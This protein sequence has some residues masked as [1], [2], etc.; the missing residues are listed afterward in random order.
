MLGARILSNLAELR[1]DDPALLRVMAWRLSQAGDLET[2]AGVLEKVLRLRPEEPQSKRDLA[3]V[4]A[5]LAEAV[6]KPAEAERA[7]DLLY[8]VVTRP[9]DR[10]PE[11]ELIALME[12]NRILVRAERRGWAGSVRGDRVDRRLRKLLDLDLRVSLAWDADMTDVDL[13]VLEPTREHAF[14]GH[15]LTTAVTRKSPAISRRATSNAHRPDP[16]M[17]SGAKPSVISN[18]CNGRVIGI[19]KRI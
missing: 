9:Q 13:H 12:L 14:Y 8:D 11:I 5:D 3:L 2:A 18:T 17:S 10:F 7:V 19:L 16:A 15:R 6:G 4:L 1:I